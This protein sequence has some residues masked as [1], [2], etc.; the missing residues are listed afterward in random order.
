LL[1]KS[2]LSSIRARLEAIPAAH[3]QLP[4]P[5]ITGPLGAPGLARYNR[6]EGLS[7]G[8]AADLD[9]GPLQAG[10]TI[11]LGMADLVPNAELTLSREG[12]RARLQ[13]GAYRRLTTMDPQARPFSPGGSLSSLLLG[14]DE[15]DYFRT[16]GVEL[17]GAP[18]LSRPRWYDWRLYA[19]RERAAE[20]ETD[21]SLPH[22]FDR[23]HLFPV[24]DSARE[25][26]QFGAAIR[27]NGG[28]GHD[29]LGFRTRVELG[30]VAATGSFDYA[31][32]SLTLH[33]GFPLPGPFVGMLEGAAGT[34]IGEPASQ[35]LWRIGGPATLRGYA[36]GALAGESFWRGRA[37]V[38]TQLPAARL[39]L[40]SDA[41]WAGSFERVASDPWL[42]SAGVGVSLL[43]GL[44]RLDLSRALKA[45]TGW[46]F[47]A[48]LDAWQ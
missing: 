5:R 47:T 35:H 2:E 22:L 17:M 27:L 46:R 6:V 1:T 42:H 48:Y 23:D 25:A 34:T 39:I 13:L 16:L 30:V 14:R 43:D 41:G 7:L 36:S 9:F 10:A 40:F 8:V 21:F 15:D 26:T 37:E 19:Q 11:R 18:R 44:V 31:R 29:P 3:W 33:T 38:A 28:W 24:N 20:K 12:A 4:G 45:P 32:S